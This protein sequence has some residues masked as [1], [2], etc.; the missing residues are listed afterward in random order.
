MT[1]CWQS[2]ILS[3]DRRII[4]LG[5]PIVPLPEYR[6]VRMKECGPNRYPAFSQTQSSLLNRDVQHGLMVHEHRR[7]NDWHLS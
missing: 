5:T 2:S 1:T 3:V 4:V 6:A 7:R